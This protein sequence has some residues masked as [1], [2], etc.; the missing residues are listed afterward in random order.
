M[1]RRASGSSRP[2][3]DERQDAI[4]EAAERLLAERS[5]AD[6]SIEQLAGAA[7]ISRPT[8]YFYFASKDE[9]LL[10]LLGRVIA[11]AQSRVSAL[12]RD[13]SQD[14]ATAWREAIGVFVDVFTEHRAVSAAALATR[15]QNPQIERLWS[16]A[17]Q[18]WTDFAAEVIESERRRGAA[19]MGVN[20][21][22]LSVALNL[23]NERVLSAA[24]TGETPRIERDNAHEVLTSIWLSAIYGTV[25]R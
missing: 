20:A 17:M 21:R 24:F 4:V 14:A 8:F 12:P 1:A 16:T 22:D 3:G 2:T 13:F 7:G 9:V 11:E 6:I 5:L 15:G 19:P 10:E 23:M 25:P 18:T